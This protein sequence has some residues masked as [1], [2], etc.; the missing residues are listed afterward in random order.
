MKY[1]R[2]MTWKKEKMPGAKI[3][4]TTNTWMCHVSRNFNRKRKKN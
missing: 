3:K 2:R 4:A 1:F